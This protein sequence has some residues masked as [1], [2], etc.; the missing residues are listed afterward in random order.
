MELNHYSELLI[1]IK[2][3]AD[4]DPF[5]NTVTQ[6]SFDKLDLDKGNIFPILHIMIT[7][8]SF[9]NGQTI[10]LNVEILALQQRDINN[11]ERTDKFWGQDNEVDNLNEML[12]V[13]NRMWIAMFSDFVENDII[14]S[15]DPTLD[16]I[17]PETT[18]NLIEGWQMVFEVE[19]P[20]T[21]LSLCP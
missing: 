8:G 2:S 7:G 16:I 17:E 4:A 19:M 21:S 9:T 5:I 18:T 11:E 14:A 1:Y 15:E 13:L 3:L 6:G 12:A 10:K 20:N